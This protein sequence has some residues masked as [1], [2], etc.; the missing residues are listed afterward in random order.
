[1]GIPVALTVWKEDRPG[2]GVHSFF[3]FFGDVRGYEEAR[4][5]DK[6]K[7]VFFGVEGL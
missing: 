7:L 1:M 6:K 5:G 3:F 2:N 4:D